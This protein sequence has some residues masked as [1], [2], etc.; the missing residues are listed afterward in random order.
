VHPFNVIKHWPDNSLLHWANLHHP[1]LFKGNMKTYIFL[2]LN[3]FLY[4]KSEFNIFFNLFN[5]QPQRNS[6]PFSDKTPAT[7]AK[8]TG[9]PD[10]FFQKCTPREQ[11]WERESD[12]YWEA[13]TSWVHANKLL[14][15][16]DFDIVIILQFNATTWNSLYVGMAEWQQQKQSEWRSEPICPNQDTEPICPRPP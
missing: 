13:K 4:L 1:L 8:R 7:P 5:N 9:Y 14:Y 15:L 3:V 2:G 10:L 12:V 16:T 11:R 6:H